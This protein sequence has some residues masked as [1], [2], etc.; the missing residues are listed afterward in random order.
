LTQ[1]RFSPKAPSSAA[2]WAVPKIQQ[3]KAKQAAGLEARGKLD[4]AQAGLDIA[5]S[6]ANMAGPWGMVAGGVLKLIS[7]FMNINGPRQ[8][9]QRR[10][11]EQRRR[12]S[13]KHS[14]MRSNAAAAGMQFAGGMLRTGGGQGPQATV[15]DPTGPTYSFNPSTSVHGR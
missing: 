6:A 8:K 2:A 11:A 7:A 13:A 14:A 15:A 5:A 4:K 10:R 1:H 9:K 3:A 12:I